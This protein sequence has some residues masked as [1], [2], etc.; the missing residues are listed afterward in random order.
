MS[1]PSATR[2]RILPGDD[3]DADNAAIREAYERADA[4]IQALK[5]F[6]ASIE[7]S[8]RDAAKAFYDSGTPAGRTEAGPQQATEELLAMRVAVREPL[9]V[10]RR[11]LLYRYVQE[12]AKHFDRRYGLR[13]DERE[14]G[15]EPLEFSGK[16]GGFEGY[17]QHV[18]GA[19]D[20]QR[21]L[22]AGTSI[23][24]VSLEGEG[25]AELE[26]YADSREDDGVPE[27]PDPEGYLVPV[28]EMMLR[29]HRAMDEMRPRTAAVRQLIKRAGRIHTRYG[30]T[31]ADFGGCFERTYEE[32]FMAKAPNGWLPEVGRMVGQF[33]RVREAIR[34][35]R[36]I[37]PTALPVPPWAQRRRYELGMDELPSNGD[38][39]RVVTGFSVYK[40]GKCRVHFADDVELV[41]FADYYA[42]G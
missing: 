9:S 37:L 35:D 1:T 8:C 42:Q 31:W 15:D 4:A 32:R 10:R 30:K 33:V 26:R 5:G 41:A 6:E 14:L 39:P 36:G 16:D 18:T 2:P 23:R 28:S 11:A 3:L 29:L 22:R 25:L 7:R 13:V 12:C 34:E 40:N 27:R 21:G 20:L 19:A 24:S 38:R 17:V